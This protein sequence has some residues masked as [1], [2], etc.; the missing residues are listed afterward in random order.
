MPLFRYLLTHKSCRQIVSY[1]A[2]YI[3][4]HS[5]TPKCQLTKTM[6][7]TS[8][9]QAV[10]QVTSSHVTNPLYAKNDDDVQTASVRIR[11]C[12]LET[13]P[14]SFYQPLKIHRRKRAD[15]L[16]K[17]VQKKMTHEKGSH[18][19]SAP[20][21]RSA[22]V[23]D[24]RSISPSMISLTANQPVLEPMRSR[25]SSVQSVGSKS[26]KI[27]SDTDEEAQQKPSL[28]QFVFMH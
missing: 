14:L 5:L 3:Y 2:F 24:N 16:L 6:T 19:L 26:K 18:D 9:D 23:T 13:H 21:K 11:G 7:D 12:F 27:I 22:T 28:F 4:S 1:T 25:S 20:R 15:T 8:S 10:N 17:W